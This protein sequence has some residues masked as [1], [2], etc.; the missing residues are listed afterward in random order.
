MRLIRNDAKQVSCPLCYARGNF[1]VT[2][3]QYVELGKL[4]EAIK[5]MRVHYCC[6]SARHQHYCQSCGYLD[7]F[8]GEIMEKEE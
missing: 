7:S 6:C 1:H 2:K 4:R 8:F 3:E 5:E